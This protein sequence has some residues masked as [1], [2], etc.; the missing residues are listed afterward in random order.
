MVDAHRQLMDPTEGG[1]LHAPRKFL[2]AAAA[3]AMTAAY[4][5]A[6]SAQSLSPSFTAG[7]VH[8]FTMTDYEGPDRWWCGDEG[9]CNYVGDSWND[10]I[11]SAR[12]EDSAILV[13]LWD[14]WDCTGGSIT[15]DSSGY[16][17]IGSWVSGYRIIFH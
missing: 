17:A 12:T 7:C 16:H 8:G 1:A 3:L 2:A 10:K 11:R 13:E 14:N 9:K 6:A 4:A 5:P 15:V